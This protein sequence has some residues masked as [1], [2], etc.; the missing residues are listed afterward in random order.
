MASSAPRGVLGLAKRPGPLS[1]P[2]VAL[3]GVDVRRQN[4]NGPADSVVPQ[5]VPLNQ[6]VD[7]VRGDVQAICRLGHRKGRSGLASPGDGRQASLTPAD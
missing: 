4:A 6:I 1:R 7:G 5:F 2:R 3:V